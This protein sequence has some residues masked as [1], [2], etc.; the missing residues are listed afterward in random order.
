MSSFSD[1]RALMSR[2]SLRIFF[3]PGANSVSAEIV[4]AIL[5][6]LEGI[7]GFPRLSILRDNIRLTTTT[8]SDRTGAARTL[9]AH[10]STG[11]IGFAFLNKEYATWQDGYVVSFSKL[12][13]EREERL[14]IWVPPTAIDK[15]P[16]ALELAAV[17]L[18]AAFAHWTPPAEAQVI[19]FQ[20][21][22]VARQAAAPK[23]V[24]EFP[25]L[26][27]PNLELR[28]Q[29]THSLRPD[30]VGWGI[31]DI[32]GWV[33]YWSRETSALLGFP[34]PT[35]D[36]PLLKRSHQTATGAWLVRL[37]DEPLDLTREDHRQ[38]V[39]WAYARFRAVGT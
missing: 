17:L 34:N 5:E 30:I 15:V 1:Y 28:G 19:T 11:D 25:R 33:N 29:A 18:D 39:G 37:T 36:A 6:G 22:P 3:A 20:L 38:V 24:R 16:Q 13:P 35:I 12:R 7:A 9:L 31:Y 8:P 4:R 2:D 10:T 27:L 21:A 23:A 14:E 32:I 26:G